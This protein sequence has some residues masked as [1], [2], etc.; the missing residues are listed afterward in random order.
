MKSG[1]A[2][3]LAWPET[4]C[5]QAG[6]WYDGLLKSL[7][8]N[9]DHYYQAGHAALLLIRKFDLEIHYFDFGRYHA[10]IGFG[11]V[12]SAQTDPELALSLTAEWSSSGELKN[13][14]AILKAL[15][16]NPAYHG[17]GVLH[18]STS[19]VDFEKAIAKA[20]EIQGFSPVK[21]GPFTF[22]GSNCSRFVNTVL[23]HSRPGIYKKLRL[24][25]PW[26]LTPSPMSNVRSF[27]KIYQDGSP[28]SKG[29]P[30]CANPKLPITEPIK[31]KSIP[32]HALWLSGEGA[33]S[34]FTVDGYYEDF[35]IHRFSPT[36]Q[37][38]FSGIFIL[39]E[40]RGVNLNEPYK[41]DYLSHFQKITIIQN[42]DPIKLKLKE[43]R[44]L[45]KLLY[46]EVL[47]TR[48]LWKIPSN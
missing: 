43:T 26:T 27:G 32:D 17:D 40:G 37:V 47:S 46:M 42:N 35:L 6:G 22:G 14:P 44:N 41:I 45:Y 23:L 7:G 18:A 9:R 36:G 15:N 16:A 4:Y 48:G 34:W 21:Y 12:R 11:R 28:N 30:F 20:Q 24:Y 31:H 2:I 10:P 1:I 19:K 25:F 8:F 29:V 38:E 33:G 3:A 39:D 13:L 5:K